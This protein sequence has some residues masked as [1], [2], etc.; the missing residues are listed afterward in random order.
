MRWFYKPHKYTPHLL[1]WICNNALQVWSPVFH[2]PS[3][4]DPS[5]HWDPRR[6][7]P[8]SSAAWWV[9]SFLLSLL[10][11]LSS[12]RN[13]AG[14]FVLWETGCSCRRPLT[15]LFHSGDN[16]VYTGID[17]RWLMWSTRC[18]DEQ[19]GD[20]SSLSELLSSPVLSPWLSLGSL[21]LHRPPAGSACLYLSWSSL[22]CG[23]GRASAA[24]L[25]SRRWTGTQET[26][27]EVQVR[28]VRRSRSFSLHTYWSS[29]PKNF[30]K[31][32]FLPLGFFKSFGGLTT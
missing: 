7:P 22:L 4:R 10:C 11:R 19:V 3:R 5:G 31:W 32:H 15:A 27:F 8:V 23:R 16:S 17:F 28:W 29:V 9:S 24:L 14:H 26:A 21:P 2:R 30:T 13:A 12:V 18:G 6:P 1:Y 25:W 20:F